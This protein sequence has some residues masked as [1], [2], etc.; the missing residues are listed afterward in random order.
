MMLGLWFLAGIVGGI[1][2][3]LSQQWTVAH[4]HAD[5]TKKVASYLIVG[6]FLRLT[7]A[8]LILYAAIQ[9]SIFAALLAFAGLWIA[10]WGLSIYWNRRQPF[11]GA[12]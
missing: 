10:R 1:L 4:L 9:Q 2:S 8:G 7:L 6:F 3:G 12:K 5:S 11:S